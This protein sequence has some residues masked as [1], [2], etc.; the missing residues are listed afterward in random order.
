[1]RARW[2]AARSSDCRRRH[3][4]D[5]LKAVFQTQAH[6]F[7]CPK[8]AGGASFHR[9]MFRRT[10]FLVLVLPFLGAALARAVDFDKDIKPILSKNC[11]ECHS[12]QKNKEK[13]GFVFD[14]LA[15][16]KKDIGVNLI[17]EPG[18]P[19]ESH[20]FEVLADPDIK[21]HMPRKGNLSPKDLEKIRT[22]ITEGAGLDANAPKLAG[23]AGPASIMS[24]TNSDGAAIS[25]GF[26]G[27]KGQSVVFKMPNG[28][29]VEYPIKKLSPAS[30][31]Q[32]AECA[33]SLGQ[34]P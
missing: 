27:I 13:G 29:K 11:Y 9:M 6:F 19:G 22:W 10:L 18:K 32:V 24:W 12:E 2:K 30:Q 28:T 31:R 4:G 1:M 34:N 7:V 26:G 33:V 15:R 3:W 25:A 21:N 23:K 8:K 14:N 17:I 20:F 5:A 16:F